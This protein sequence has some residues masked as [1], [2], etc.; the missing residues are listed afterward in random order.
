MRKKFKIAF[1]YLDD[2]HQLL[3]FVGP[4]IE[5][6]KTEEVKLITYPGE[7]RFLYKTIKRLGG[8]K[9]LVEQRK[10][11]AFRAFTDKLKSRKRPRISFWIKKNK[12]HLLR[13]YDALVFPDYYHHY[14]H[15]D[16]GIKDKPKLIYISHGVSG[17]AY[18]YRKD[19]LDFDSYL[20]WGDY[21]I[22][23]LK[24]LNRLPA[25]HAK[26]G[27]P[28]LDAIPKKQK[29]I[30]FKNNRPTVLYNP[31]FK[32]LLSSWHT[33]GLGVLDYFYNQTKPRGLVS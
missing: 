1:L 25:H 7:H 33:K 13:E 5:L 8:D 26:V 2:I 27:Y 17:H 10:T 19:I 30:S 32:P 21:V 31:H 14:I 23:H 24:K 22:E 18:A 16:R 15:R 3:H 9:S 12:N 28:K 29:A 20:L 4:A 6:A 11:K